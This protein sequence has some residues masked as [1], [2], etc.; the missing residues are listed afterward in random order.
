MIT[1]SIQPLSRKGSTVAQRMVRF[2]DLTN[3]IIDDDQLVRLVV[4]QHPA[5]EDGPVEIEV[6]REEVEPIRKQTLN[7]VSLKLYEGD[8]T[9]PE[10]VTMDADAF[11]KLAGDMD[12]VWPTSSAGHS[13][14]TRLVERRR[15]RLLRP[16][17]RSTT[18]QWTMRDGQSGAK[19]QTRRKRL[20]RLTWTKLMSD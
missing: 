13:L 1:S 10:S 19:S 2:S 15:H 16:P 17:K 3:K 8:S 4:D 9:E 5:L 20:W 11:N 7:V 14:L 12:T 18:D 6:M